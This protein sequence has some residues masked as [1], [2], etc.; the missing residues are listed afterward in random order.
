MMDKQTVNV[1]DNVSFLMAEVSYYLRRGFKSESA[2]WSGECI[3][4]AYRY[5][6]QLRDMGVST[7][8]IH[9]VAVNSYR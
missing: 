4:R 5:M 2:A 7:S 1:V 6:I 9:E 8:D 3:G